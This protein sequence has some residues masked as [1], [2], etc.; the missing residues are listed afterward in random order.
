VSASSAVQD[1]PR[2]TGTTAWARNLPTP[3]RSFLRTETG[4]AAVLL[5]A[6]AAALVWANVDPH[7]YNGV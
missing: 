7:S 5:A 6:A 3:L 2:F 4:S 1:R